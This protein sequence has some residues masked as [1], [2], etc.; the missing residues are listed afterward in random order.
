MLGSR[1]PDALMPILV[2]VGCI[3][4]MD[5][6]HL[7]PFVLLHEETMLQESP[8]L[9]KVPQAHQAGAAQGNGERR[10]HFPWYITCIPLVYHLHV[11]N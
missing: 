1:C 9:Q 3:Q 8:A 10:S 7:P 11:A 5:L 2:A 6:S 4:P